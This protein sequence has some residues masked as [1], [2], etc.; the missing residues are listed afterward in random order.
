MKKIFS[1]ISKERGYTLLFSVLTAVLVL[2]VAVFIL[3]VARKQYVLSS[4]AQD[5]LGSLYNADSGV[6][7]LVEAGIGKDNYVSGNSVTIK[8][9]NATPPPAAVFA[10]ANAGVETPPSAFVSNIVQAPGPSNPPAYIYLPFT[11]ATNSAV[12]RGCALIKI[13]QGTIADGTTRTVVYSRGY[14]QCDHVAKIPKAGPRT[15]ERAM[16]FTT[17]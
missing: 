1:T 5:S 9:N 3:G 12:E 11:D 13:W 2:S 10:S 15:V 7:C 8:C 16:Q 6:E 17:Q 4:A 14:N